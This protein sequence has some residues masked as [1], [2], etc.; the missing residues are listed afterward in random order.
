[1]ITYLRMIIRNVLT[2]YYDEDKHTYS[3]FL[4]TDKKTKSD[5]VLIMQ[6]LDENISQETRTRNDFVLWFK[7]MRYS[8]KSIDDAI[9]KGHQWYEYQEDIEEKDYLPLYYLYVL[10]YLRALDGYSSAIYEAKKFRSRCRK[11]CEERRRDF[12][13]L[14]YD[15]VRDWLGNDKG[16]KRL[17]DDHEA[18][19]TRLM[20]DDRYMT[21]QGKFKEIDL[22]SRRIFGYMEITDPVFLKGT[23]VFFK[24]NECGVS[25]RQIEHLF[26]FK[27]GF[28]LERL[29]AF[30]KSVV[31]I[32]GNVT[33]NVSEYKNKQLIVKKP[34]AIGD[35]VHINFFTYQKEKGRLK[36]IISENGKYAFLYKSEVSYE[37]YIT[38]SDME[39][40]VGV[41]SE[42]P[43]EVKTIAYNDK[44]DYYTVSLK[45]L[46]L[47][48]SS[49]VEHSDLY[50]ALKNIK[51]E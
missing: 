8:D 21:V 25:A 10:Y 23:K 45:Q 42:V 36:G 7:L 6:Y 26:E 3:K 47:G 38:D 50:N 51:I 22:S 49:M 24:P 19:Y 39:I 18:D 30:D 44:L 16:L 34:I 1:M 40:Y 5:L 15:R 43:I 20:A 17:L 41:D 35:I 37:K 11:V 2:K 14:N 31:D 48:E 12:S 27:V 9:K 13:K 33:K 29:V 32:S 4:K 46:V 28:S